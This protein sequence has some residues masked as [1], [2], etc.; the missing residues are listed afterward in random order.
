MI[1]LTIPS[2]GQDDLDAVCEVL[3]SGFLVQG[4]RVAAFEEQ[5]RAVTGT[6]HVVAVSSGTAALH[7]ALLALNVAPGDLVP[8]T[9]YSWISTANVIEL[10][11][12]Q[13]VF[14]DIDPASYNMD[15]GAL[16]AALNTLMANRETA[17]RV[18]A[19]LPIDAF[20]LMADMSSICAVAAR[21]GIPVLEDA[22]CAL[23]ASWNGHPAGSLGALGAFSF[24]P[25]KAITTGEGGAVSTNDDTLA[26]K[27]KALRNHGLDP[28]APTADFVLPGFNYRLS[29]F[30]AAF[31]L[32]QLRKMDRIIAARRQL[33]ARYTGLVAGTGIIS[34]AG[35]PSHQSVFQS[36]VCLLPESA[37][38]RRPAL[39]AA[40]KQ[41]G[42]ETTIGTWHMPMT[43]YFRTR[44]GFRAGDFPATDTV[45]SRA[46]SLPLYEGLTAPQQE[47]VVQALRTALASC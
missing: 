37:A 16:E 27:L 14:I 23:G 32:T 18:K 40:L 29:E 41:Q 39:I 34:P 10:C 33:A 6:K 20:G 46:L 26:W 28:N 15:P 31:G 38:A 42:V 7:V 47:S 3:S 45:F 4:P 2:I 35:R 11:G 5:L 19:I 30:Q 9:A 36:Y 8:V 17:R 12:A 24:H 21:H 1:R 13:P 44:Y 22:A 25:R 43:T